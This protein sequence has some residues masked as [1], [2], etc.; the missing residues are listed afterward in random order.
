MHS[1]RVECVGDDHSVFVGS[2]RHC[3]GQ[4]E[5]IQL[6]VEEIVADSL[7]CCKQVL[8]GFG[9]FVIDSVGIV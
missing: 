5:L 9:G 7:H 3:K 8:D 6:L 1:G 4:E 2:C